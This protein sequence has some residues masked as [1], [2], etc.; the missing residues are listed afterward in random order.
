MREGPRGLHTYRPR[1]S[2]A[3]SH[4][5]LIALEPVAEAFGWID[6]EAKTLLAFQKED[7]TVRRSARRGPW[8]TAR[9]CG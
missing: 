1:N 6:S 8:L 3:D 4:P 5:Y 7:G 9:T 2:G